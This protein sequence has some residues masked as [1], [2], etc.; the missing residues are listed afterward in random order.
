M[1]P[2]AD[3]DA[4]KVALTALQFF[5]FWKMSCNTAARFGMMTGR[6]LYTTFFRKWKTGV[7]RTQRYPSASV[8]PCIN[9]VLVNEAFTIRSARKANHPNFPEMM[10]PH[11]RLQNTHEHGRWR[12]CEA[13]QKVAETYASI[14]GARGYQHVRDKMIAACSNNRN[15]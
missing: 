10:A 12:H 11:D 1:S 5:I 13:S 15:S 4:G 8:A 7:Q 6:A 9:R 14:V 2:A 3:V